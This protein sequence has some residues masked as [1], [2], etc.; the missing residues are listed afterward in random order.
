M[1]GYILEWKVTGRKTP[2]QEAILKEIEELE[3]GVNGLI[4]KKMIDKREEQQTFAV[5]LISENHT[6]QEKK[7]QA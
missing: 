2:I 4:I 6:R 7:M 5:Q 1:L 3:K